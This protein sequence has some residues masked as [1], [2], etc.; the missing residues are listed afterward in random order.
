VLGSAIGIPVGVFILEYVRPAFI[1]TAVGV[2]L[3]AFSLYNLTRPKFPELKGPGRAGDVG[4][5][6]L[7]GVL[8]AST[9]LG[10]ILPVIW[11]TLRGWTRDEQRGVHQPTAF[12]TFVM[13]IVGLGG[14]G[15]VTPAT[16]HLLLLG[17]P[18]L[19]AGT[20]VGWALYGKLDEATFR[21]I[22]LVL[23]LLS[24]LAIVLTVRGPA[25]Q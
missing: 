2:L 19:I 16:T 12:A 15:L 5:G 21:K 20:L 22:V 14:A 18:V 3:I 23:L 25:S 7:N 17:F 9:G 6:I 10:G 4:V 1:R 13:S 8:G 24:G 11:T